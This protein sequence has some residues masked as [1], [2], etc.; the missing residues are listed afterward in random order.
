MLVCEHLPPNALRKEHVIDI[1]TAAPSPTRN[2]IVFELEREAPTPLHEQISATMRREIRRGAWP[3][4]MRLPAEPDLAETLGVSRGTVRRALRSL[5]DEGLLVQVRGRGTFVTSTSIEQPIGQELLSLAEGLEREGIAF[6]TEVIDASVGIP[7]ESVGALL[8]IEPGEVL[9]QIRRRRLIDGAPVAFLVNYVRRELCPG[10]EANDFRRVTMF[11]LL[12][13]VYG[14][15]IELGRRTFEAQAASE[16]IAASL[17][18]EPGAPVLY[19]EQ[20]TYLDDGRPIEYS[21]V[22]IRGDRLKLSSVLRRPRR[23]AD[24]SS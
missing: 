14:L 6:E 7:P 11:G 1:G 19:L 5:I 12:E 21:D 10:I 20:L 17:R 15:H 16:Q 13:T 22:W 18:I 23:P 8:A 24:T 9:F 2:P 4:H 3:A